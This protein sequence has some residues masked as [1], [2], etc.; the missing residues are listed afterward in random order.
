MSA[1]KSNGTNTFKA[2]NDVQV[3]KARDLWRALAEYYALKAFNQRVASSS[4]SLKTV[5]EKIHLLYGLWC[6][7]KHLATFYLGNFTQGGE[8]GDL[9]RG[10]LLQKCKQ[11]KDDA[12][13]IAD[14]L[15]PPDWVLN[16]IL[17]KSDGKVSCHQFQRYFTLGIHENFTLWQ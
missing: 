12:V 2:R 8:F 7:E 4:G 1:A 14:S 10:E 17:G 5:L 13:S 9:I 11:I 16:S 3:F 6:L 15:A